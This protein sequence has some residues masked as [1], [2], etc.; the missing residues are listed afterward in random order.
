MSTI[1]K[2]SIREKHLNKQGLSVNKSDV[3]KRIQKAAFDAMDEWAKI[4]AIGFAKWI[5]QNAYIAEDEY[6]YCLLKD[7]SIVTEESLYELYIQSKK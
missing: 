5:P 7:G 6:Y 3:G 2:E 4:D 1:N